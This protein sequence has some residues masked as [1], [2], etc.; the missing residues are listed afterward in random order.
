MARFKH[1]EIY[2]QT[3][4]LNREIFRIK[5]K[6]PKTLKFDLGEFVFRSSL[7]MIRGIVIANGTKDKSKVLQQIAL[8]IELLWVY[9]R[10]LYDFQG[11]SRGEFQVLSEQLTEIS[12]QNQ[13]WIKWSKEQIFKT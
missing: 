12:K 11:I 4:K 8:E 13:K 5:Q 6:L 2:Q 10:M 7:R 3:Y 9:F 1:L